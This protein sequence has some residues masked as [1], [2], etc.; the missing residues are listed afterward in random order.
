MKQNIIS[1][2]GAVLMA[3]LTL[4]S[5]SEEDF[6]TFDGQKS[7]IYIQKV[8]T[9]TI[10]GTPI[11]FTDSVY[12]TFANYGTEYKEMLVKVPVYIMG[13]LKD[14]D[15]QFILTVDE[16]RT[17]AR[18]GID[19]EFSDTACYIPAGKHQQDVYIK[20]L[21]TDILATTDLRI[22]LELKDNENFTV[23]LTS[24][25]SQANWASA[26]SGKE[27]CGSRYKIIFNDTYTYTMWWEWYG[28]D[29]Y[30][31]WSIKKEK[32]LNELMGWTHYDWERWKVPYGLMGYSAKKMQKYL[33]AAA[34]SGNPIREDD[35]TLMQLQPPYMVDY[36][37]YTD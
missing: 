33:Q 13:D 23:E 17:T 11:S 35:G 27:L 5:C 7:G 29:I 6:I 15:R 26:A 1:L 3:A 12:F 8:N 34:D 32:I 20:L 4:T 37:Q 24:Y 18:N 31:K 19:Y 22:E 10:S 36:S 28:D 21:R 9:T 2:C 30:G 16:S 14:Y 25:N